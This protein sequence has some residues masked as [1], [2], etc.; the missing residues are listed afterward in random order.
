MFRYHDIA[1]DHTVGA[2]PHLLQHFK[3]QI[4]MAPAVV[5]PTFRKSRKV[6]QPKP[7]AA[8]RWA[9]PSPLV[10]PRMVIPAWLRDGA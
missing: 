4:A 8:Q 5:V 10:F 6:G 7:V 3:E 1:D 9:S 2:P